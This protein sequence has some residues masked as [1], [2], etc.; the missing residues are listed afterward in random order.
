MNEI[1]EII[2]ETT[3]KIMQDL[4]TK[5]VLERAERGVYPTELWATLVETGLTSIGISEEKG[6]SGGSIAD[7]LAVLRIAGKFAA[8]IP[9]AETLMANWILAKAGM[10]LV[11]QPATVV[12][13]QHG[14][15]FNETAH[16][17]TVTGTA[18]NVPWA[19]CAELLIV[20]GQCEQKTILA[21]VDAKSCQIE[22]EENLAGEPRN[23]VI[24]DSVEVLNSRVSE[25]ED[26]TEE[27]WMF[28]GALVRA[29]QM[30]GALERMLDLTVQYSTERIQFGRPIARFQAIQQQIAVLAG[31][32]IAASAITEL[33]VNA[34]EAG[35]S[36][37]QIMSAKI[38]VGEAASK[39]V[40]IAHQIHGAIGFTDEHALQHSTRRLWSWR[41][42]FGNESY[43]ANRLGS[44]VLDEGADGLWPLITSMNRQIE[45]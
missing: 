26:F 33:A 32:V 40:P 16:G 19:T 9:I 7:A 37:Q 18:Y 21:V 14:I 3:E 8:P 17:W 29:N 42:E 5:E 36:K 10:T 31:E 12:F 34:F 13:N 28:E 24:L 4:C 41:D 20:I 35:K 27:K 23:T 39:G 25:L 15:H 38:R 6:G 44:T 2:K 45:A 1:S 43:W 22:Y 30:T 11:E